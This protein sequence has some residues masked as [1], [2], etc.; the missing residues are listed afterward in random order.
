MVTKDERKTFQTALLFLWC[1]ISYEDEYVWCFFCKETIKLPSQAPDRRHKHYILLV[2]CF[3]FFICPW[4]SVLCTFSLEISF[5]RVHVWCFLPLP[6]S[7]VIYYFHCWYVCKCLCFWLKTRWC[8]NNI[9]WIL[10]M[11]ASFILNVYFWLRN[12]FHIGFVYLKILFSCV[13]SVFFLFVFC[14]LIYILFLKAKTND[15]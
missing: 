4:L 3:V 10:Y 6:L 14:F 5:Y 11:F 15:V 9:W 7:P 2:F 12:A 8:C 1:F 13:R